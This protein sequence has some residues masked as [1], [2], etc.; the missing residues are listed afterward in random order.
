M[1]QTGRISWEA[2]DQTRSPVYIRGPATSSYE[3]QAFFIQ[4]SNEYPSTQDL[5]LSTQGKANKIQS[6]T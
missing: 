3:H 4:L 6:L 1:D 5:E 2:E